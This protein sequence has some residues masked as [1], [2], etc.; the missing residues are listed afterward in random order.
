[1]AAFNV[2][3]VDLSPWG[4]DDKFDFINPVTDLFKAKPYPG[5]TDLATVKAVTLPF[6][7]NLNAYPNVQ[8]VEA[9][10]ASANAGLKPTATSTLK[11]STVKA[12]TIATKK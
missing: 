7:Q 5:T 8:A 1:M 10:L 9:A 12:T 6:F 3:D 11:T 4:Y 2:T